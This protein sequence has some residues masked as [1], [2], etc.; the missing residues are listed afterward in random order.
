MT[1]LRFDRIKSRKEHNCHLCGLR[2]RKGAKCISWAATADGEFSSGYYHEV[3]YD[4]F[5]E[6]DQV[7][8]EESMFSHSDF[9]HEELHMTGFLKQSRVAKQAQA[10][11]SE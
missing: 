5:S 2:I 8:Q 10:A 7:D 3:C 6:W 11:E 1:T 9:R 4:H